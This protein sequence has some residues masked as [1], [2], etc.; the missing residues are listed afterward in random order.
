MDEEHRQRG[1][2]PKQI[3]PGETLS[4]FPLQPLIRPCCLHDSYRPA[5]AHEKLFSRSLPHYRRRS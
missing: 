1:D 2:P 5:Q 4:P 3:E